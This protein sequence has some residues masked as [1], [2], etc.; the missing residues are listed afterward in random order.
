MAELREADALHK[1]ARI[2]TVGHV[3]EL[4]AN[5]YRCRHCRQQDQTHS[6]FDTRQISKNPEDEIVRPR[7][8]AAT[9][10]KIRRVPCLLARLVLIKVVLCFCL[11]H[12]SGRV[13]PVVR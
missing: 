3:Y 13:R 7:V 1:R 2:L 11:A 9:M 5:L 12:T 8:D 10:G 4:I 6:Q